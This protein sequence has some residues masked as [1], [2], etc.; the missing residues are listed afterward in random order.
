M[1][2]KAQPQFGKVT[3]IGNANG[4]WQ[5]ATHGYTIIFNGTI[6]SGDNI[7]NICNGPYAGSTE[8]FVVTGPHSDWLT[9]NLSIV[10]RELELKLKCWPSSGLVSFVLF[11]RLNCDLALER[12]SLL[13]SLKRS[14]DMSLKQHLPCVVHNWLGERRI[15]IEV[16]Q[17]SNAQQA[18]WPALLLNETAAQKTDFQDQ[19]SSSVTQV[20]PI[21][22]SILHQIHDPYQ[23]MIELT[24]QNQSSHAALNN[25][26]YLNQ[27]P[28]S[29]WLAVVTQ[30]KLLDVEQVFFDQYPEKLT[31]FWYLSDNEASTWLDKI[32]FNLA[33]C[34]Q[35]LSDY[36]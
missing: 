19:K 15:A 31:G 21:T 1:T 30:Q 23:L 32:R 6:A 33:L 8:D 34:Q 3:I 26:R 29:A 27:L 20:I 13:P 35:H 10:A 14:E 12:M 16:H 2:S 9:T 7:I 5:A 11:S 24:L 22:D 36:Q 4:D 25:L 18:M 28:Q 17:Q